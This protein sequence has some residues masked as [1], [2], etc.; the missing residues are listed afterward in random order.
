MGAALREARVEQG[1]L[2]EAETDLA[3]W[4]RCV[5]LNISCLR[6]MFAGAEFAAADGDEETSASKG[7]AL[8][9][10]AG[11]VL[12]GLARHWSEAAASTRAESFEPVLRRLKVHCS[13]DVQSRPRVLV[14]GCGL[15]RLA[16]EIAKELA[17]DV[18]AN[19]ESA[20]ALAGL[21]Y[22]LRGGRAHFCPAL[23]SASPGLGGAGERFREEEVFGGCDAIY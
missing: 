9:D 23:L 1:L 19:D 16:V 10:D 8:Y 20:A 4:R 17:A 21:A 22:L 2:A 14:V 5:D 15:G 7:S 11:Q 18:V 6:A 3:Q 12:R 13:S